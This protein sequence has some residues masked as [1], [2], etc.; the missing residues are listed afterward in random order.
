M[1]WLNFEQRSCATSQ[2]YKRNKSG[3]KEEIRQGNLQADQK[4][5]G[6]KNKKRII[7]KRKQTLRYLQGD[8]I[9][10]P[11]PQRSR[12]L[13]AKSWLFQRVA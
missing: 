4:I 6:M 12:R 10:P 3:T 7:G 11:I 9:S 1:S 8:G 5:N 2:E 13:C